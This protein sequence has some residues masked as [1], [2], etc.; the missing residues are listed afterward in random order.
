MRV[1]MP[2]ARQE[3]SSGPHSQAPSHPCAGI[4][5][6]LFQ[7]FLQKRNGFVLAILFQ[8][9]AG[10]NEQVFLRIVGFS[11]LL[12]CILHLGALARKRSL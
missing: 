11:Q 9:D 3:T 6:I 7:V 5:G 10:R 2:F 8:K 4:I 1:Q 12:G